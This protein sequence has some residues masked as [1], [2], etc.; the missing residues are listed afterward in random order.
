MTKNEKKL[1]AYFLGKASEDCGNHVCNDVNEEI[2]SDWTL[3][4]RKKFVKEFHDYNGDPEE[5]DE[6]FLHL[7]DFALMSYLSGKLLES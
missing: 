5:Y 4:E 1:A 2:F 7:P 6:D 3:E